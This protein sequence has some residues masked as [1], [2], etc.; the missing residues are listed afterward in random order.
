MSDLILERLRTELVVTEEM[1][2]AYLAANDAYWKRMDR[3][4]PLGKWRDGTPSEAT[5][6][7]LEA[8]LR[9]MAGDSPKGAKES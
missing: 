6:V 2:T 5:R 4:H 1:V 3:L 7:S 8:A 9:V